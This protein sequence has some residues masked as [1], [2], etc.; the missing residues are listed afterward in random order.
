MSFRTASEE[1]L[2]LLKSRVLTF[3]V[4]RTASEEGLPLLKSRVLTFHIF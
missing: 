4:F 3:H 1:G 2:P